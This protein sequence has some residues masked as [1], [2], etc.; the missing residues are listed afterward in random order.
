[1]PRMRRSFE[2]GRRRRLVWE[3][4]LSRSTELAHTDAGGPDPPPN[5][6]LLRKAT[7]AIP[8]VENR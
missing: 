6:F 1:M 2:S 3:A 5:C 8:R 7:T 4:V